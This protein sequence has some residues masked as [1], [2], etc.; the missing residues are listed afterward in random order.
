MMRPRIRQLAGALCTLMGLCGCGD[1]PIHL[2]DADVSLAVTVGAE[3]TTQAQAATRSD[4]ARVRFGLARLDGLTLK[5][6]AVQEVPLQGGRVAARFRNVPIGVYRGAVVA[7]DQGGAVLNAAGPALSPNVVTVQSGL[8][9]IYSAGEALAVSVPLRDAAFA[10]LPVR[11]PGISRLGAAQIEVQLFDVYTSQIIAAKRL[12]PTGP[13]PAV[14]FRNVPNGFF[15]AHVL[16]LASD[17]AVSNVLT[18]NNLAIV[19]GQ[20]ETV[21]WSAS[22]AFAVPLPL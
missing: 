11:L 9:P 5:L 20:G 21:Q 4:I 22:D 1:M 14:A 7:L 19:A 16:L 6:V 3:W 15:Q 18:S 2:A 13:S 12:T 10:T 17:G 8:A